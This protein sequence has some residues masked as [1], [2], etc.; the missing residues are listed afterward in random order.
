MPGVGIPLARLLIARNERLPARQRDWAEVKKLIDNAEKSAPESVE[1]V[2]LRAGA[3]A[4]QDR[5]AEAR[6]ELEKGQARFP[7]S[8]SHLVCPGKSPPNREA[9]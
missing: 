5:I 6:D 7:K 9:I 4:V 3:A 2:V 8:V 1:P